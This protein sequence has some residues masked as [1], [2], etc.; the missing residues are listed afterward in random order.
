MAGF[1]QYGFVI[2]L[3]VGTLLAYLIKKRITGLAK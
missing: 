1:L 3:I 2:G